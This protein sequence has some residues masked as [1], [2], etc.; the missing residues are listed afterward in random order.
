MEIYRLVNLRLS[1][2]VYDRYILLGQI[3]EES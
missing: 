1:F 2:I 3:Q